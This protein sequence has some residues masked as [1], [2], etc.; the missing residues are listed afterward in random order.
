M[1]VNPVPEGFHTVT[2][3]L[4]LEGAAK[5]I[6]FYQSAFGAKE[7]MR[8]PDPSGHKIWHATLQIGNSMIFV[9]DVFPEMGP[10][11]KQSE[12]S[13]WLYVSDVDTWFKRAVDAGATPTVPPTDMFWGD[14]MALLVDPFGQKWT[15]ASH[16]KDMTPEEMKKAQEDAIAQMK[17]GHCPS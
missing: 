8:A 14:R 11:S 5:A 15:L 2:P 12:S 6:D 13:V 7:I 9:N 3:H 10:D 4:T 16:I 1:S 17:Q